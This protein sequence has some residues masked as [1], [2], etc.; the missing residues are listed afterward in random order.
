MTYFTTLKNRH[1]KT[2]YFMGE[3][4]VF[5]K[6]FILEGN[7]ASYE[8]GKES[9]CL[10]IEFE[11]DCFI[12]V[13]LVGKLHKDFDNLK[14]LKKVRVVGKIMCDKNKHN[15]LQAELIEAKV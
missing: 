6:N 5:I 9:G 7:V 14:E 2:P 11:K 12:D 1:V 3:E 4:K 15:Y 13:V 10:K 8:K